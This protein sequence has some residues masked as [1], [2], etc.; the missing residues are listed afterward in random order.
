MDKT[1]DCVV[2]GHAC[3]D[4]TP[5]FPAESESPGGSVADI[6]RPGVLVSVGPV[7]VSCGGAVPN[8]GLPLVRLGHDVQ[9]MAKCGDDAFGRVLR[10][11]IEQAAPGVAEAVGV[12]SDDATSYTVVVAP[13]G[14]DRIFLHC[15]GANDTFGADDLDAGVLARARLV[16]FG[17]P[18]LMKR[19]YGD[20][21]DELSAIF[22]AIKDAGATA[23]LDLAYPGGAAAQA[24]WRAI[25]SAT[26]PHVDVFTPSADELLLTLRPELSRE[27]ADRSPDGS[28]GGALEMDVLSDLAGWCIEAGA[29][30]VL[31][32]CGH[33]GIYARSAGAQRVASMG[34]G[35]PGDAASWAGAERFESG[36]SARRVVSATGAGD[37]AIAGFL[38]AMLRG[39]SLGEALRVACA[40]GAFNVSA[41]DSVSGVKSWEETLSFIR[42]D[43]RRNE[44]TILRAGWR[45]GDAPGTWVGPG[46]AGS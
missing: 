6:L 31:I 1:L 20:R 37:C 32:K 7:T 22:R 35:G 34:P 18:T 10:E 13:P 30:V 17:Y 4:L 26:L 9:L 15:S 46:D 38:S 44:L 3:V 28:I 29:G 40:V 42:G 36:Y 45:A 21:G 41:P 33:L 27:L 25:L 12:S 39:L 43:R 8:V 11:R 5:A 19:L 16:H 2:A 23:S 24:D 14:I